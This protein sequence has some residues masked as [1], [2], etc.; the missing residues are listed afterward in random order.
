MTCGGRRALGRGAVRAKPTPTHLLSLSRLLLLSRVLGRR[1]HSRSLR[2][3]DL[4][5]QRR[6]LLARLGL[7]SRRDFCLFIEDSFIRVGNRNAP[8]GLAGCLINCLFVFL[9]NN[10]PR[11]DEAPLTQ[12]PQQVRPRLDLALPQRRVPAAQVLTVDQERCVA[13]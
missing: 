4:L 1:L 12:L 13:M 3:R 9:G 8:F 11:I 7:G 5:A 10:L 2:R 6:G